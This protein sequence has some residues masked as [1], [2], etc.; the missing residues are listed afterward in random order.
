[1]GNVLLLEKDQGFAMKLKLFLI[2][3]GIFLG[4]GCGQNSD[5]GDV[6]TAEDPSETMVAR[7]EAAMNSG[8]RSADDKAIDANRKPTEI[9][10]FMGIEE[11]ISVLDASAGGGYYTELLS[12]AVGPNGTVYMQNNQAS[13]QRNDVAIGARLAGGR[14]ANV[15]RI[16]RGL[17]ELGMD[18]QIDVAFAILTL[19]DQ[20]NFQGR[21]GAIGFLSAIHVALKP[22]GILAL[23]DHAGI[24]DQ[25]NTALHRIEQSIVEELINQTGLIIEASSGLLS[26]SNDSHTLN[27]RDPSIRRQTDRFVI[28][29]RKQ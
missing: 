12:A 13:A 27:I 20:Y 17:A 3:S 25:D 2:L 24:A 1:L 26:N 28:R 19:H 14:L 15:E 11:G 9:L 5:T 29:A 4:A 22:G 10:A 23:I 7:V 6:G 21:E 18:G 16:D 8:G